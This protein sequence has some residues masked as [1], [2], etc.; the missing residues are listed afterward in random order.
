M[1]EVVVIASGKGGVGKTTTTANLGAALAMAG[2]KVAVVDGD[3]GL[4]NLDVALGLED[5]IV[6][7]LVDVI[8]K[9]C[10]M[11]QAMLRVPGAEGLSLLPASQMRRK[12]EVTPEGMRLL[13]R[14]LRE[15]YDF[16]LIDCPAGID[17]GFENAI[18]GAERA[19][20]VT[21][22]E[23]A[24]VRDADRVVEKLEAAGIK[25]RALIVNRMRPELAEKGVSLRVEE[26]MDTLAIELMGVVPEDE[27]VFTM[28]SRGILPVLLPKSQAG[29]AYQNIARR[30]LGE[31]V[32]LLTQKRQKWHLFRR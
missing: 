25:K 2:K 3:I 12:D 31:S 14:E 4:R 8:E 5:K 6:Y 9:R 30:L 23:A 22:P 10:R 18:A 15:A 29:R 16:V 1:G 17:K 24:A 20:V 26:I 7:D 11:R 28:G 32:P 13:C 19:L 27:V 21:V